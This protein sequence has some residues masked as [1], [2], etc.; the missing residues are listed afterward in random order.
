MGKLLIVLMSAFL[1]AGCSS[2]PAAEPNSSEVSTVPIVDR[3]QAG[4][5]AGLNVERFSDVST[6]DPNSL[7]PYIASMKELNANTV[8]ITVQL[9]EADT[10]R[11]NFKLLSSRAVSLLN[12]SIDGLDWIVVR[13][14]DG[15]I[16]EQT[17]VG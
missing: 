7:W 16:T 8:E 3:V 12:G 2:T 15:N 6:T 13:S 17:M 1:L 4:L 14:A 9:N 5:L 11:E 10:D